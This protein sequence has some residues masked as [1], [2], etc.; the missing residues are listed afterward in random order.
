[1]QKMCLIFI[2]NSLLEN[3]K[4]QPEPIHYNECY[5]I[6]VY[7]D[8][9]KL[10]LGWNQIPNNAPQQMTVYTCIFMELTNGNTDIDKTHTR[11]SGRV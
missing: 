10:V 8:T 5:V 9:H 11:H 7:T 3:N 1:M 2:N 4:K 6:C